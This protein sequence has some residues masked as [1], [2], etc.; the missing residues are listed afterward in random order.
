[1]TLPD[2]WKFPADVDGW[3]T[4][5][6]GRALAEMAAGHDVLEIGAYCGRSTI[7]MA[8]HA[9]SVTVIDPMDGRATDKP[10]D[11]EEEFWENLRRYG[12]ADK[13]RLLR[14]T[15]VEMAPDLAV[16]FRVAFIDGAHDYISVLLDYQI[17][18][19]KLIGGGM[20]AFHDYGSPKDEPVTRAVN[21]ILADGARMLSVSGSVAAVR[22][23]QVGVP[24][25]FPFLAIPTGTGQIDY[26]THAAACSFRERFRLGTELVGCHSALCGNFN[27][28]YATA[29]NLRDK[30]VTHFVMLHDD[31]VPQAPDGMGN[32]AELMIAYMRHFELGMISAACSIKNDSGETSTAIQLGDGQIKRLT[33][34]EI[35]GLLRSDSL[36]D[37]V[38]LLANT[39]CMV[40]DIRQPWAEEIVFHQEDRIVRKDGKFAME[41]EPEDW[42]LSRWL[43]ERGVRYGVT[44]DV[45]CGHVGKKAY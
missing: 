9:N 34:A 11:T 3:L 44:T 12:V 5:T 24:V 29:L 37:S 38:T 31:V 15:S 7:C 18:V 36:A 21:T 42:R 10:R 4:E 35:G 19:S 43:H 22:P 32:W 40:I 33:R 26:R 25:T 41:F 20:V 14:G 2:S 17:A 16:G 8:Q 13:V 6:E 27:H 45:R 23:G 28:L 1:M 30:G 39:G